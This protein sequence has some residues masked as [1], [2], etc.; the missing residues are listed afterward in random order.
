MDKF[1]YEAVTNQM[2]EGFVLQDKAGR[3]V[4]FN[5]S[6]LNILGL[7]EDQLLGRTSMDP[8]WKTI[9]EDGSPFDGADHP[10]MIALNQ[11]IIVQNTI[12][13]VQTPSGELRWISI[14]AS[15]IKE[16]D[17]VIYSVTTFRDISE[18]IKKRNILND[19]QFRLNFALDASKIGIWAFDIKNNNPIW[20]DR[21][22]EVYGAS[23]ENFNSAYEAWE[24]CLLEEEKEK[25]NR[26]VNE[27]IANQKE[28]NTK[29]KIRTINNEI[30]TIAAKAHVQ[31]DHEGKTVSLIGAN[32]DITEEEND[33]E[34][35]LK[36]KLKAEE[37]TLAKSSFLANTGHEIRTPLNGILGSLELLDLKQFNEEQ[38]DILN[39]IRL[40][41]NDLLN[42][43]NNVLDISKLE[44]TNLK[45]APANLVE[46]F[47]KISKIASFNC[48]SRN[49]AFKSEFSNLELIKST[50]VLI[51][52]L[53]FSQVLNNLLSNAIKFTHKGEVGLKVKAS[54]LNSKIKLDISVHDTGIGISKENILKLFRPFEQID[55]SITR[56]YGGSGLGLVIVKKIIDQ[57]Q[58]TI[59]VD[60]I[61]Q[62]GTEFKIT[63]ILEKS[64]DK[65]I[66]EN[67]NFDISKYS[68]L[69]ILL[70]DD[71]EVNIKVTSKQMEKIGF[72]VD[73]ARSGEE[74]INK[75]SNNS[76]D[77]ILMDLQ[78]PGI[79]GYEA[80]KKILENAALSGKDKRVKIV[81]LS[82][83]SKALEFEKCQSYGIIEFCQK[84]FNKND[85]FKILVN[86][87]A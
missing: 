64:F 10:A 17:V 31:V 47:N 27:A 46:T 74:A 49:I 19:L 52:E 73:V 80:S 66:E 22:F 35:L 30:R 68:H 42:L 21:M 7:S 61:D 34:E 4:K 60:S 33:K 50:N 77:L 65:I 63:I 72:K 36:L 16:N 20:D 48:E 37:A 18:E 24:K 2:I 85:F 26:E 23:K 14:N 5:P 25:A 84:P 45:M 39:T 78:M 1:F 87:F 86:L 38:K 59:E 53:K 6:A 55:P 15:P 12:M 51:D 41:G 75:A 43:L 76:F 82:A 79:D 70:V 29:F 9:K 3:I 62:K 69:K 8:N 57:F 71:N 81:A 56:K 44:I 32:W 67:I 11:G 83:N 13:G 28:L 40:C 58:G 54:E